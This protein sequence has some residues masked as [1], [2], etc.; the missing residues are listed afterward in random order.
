MWR[1]INLDIPLR[2]HEW[3]SFPTNLANPK[4]GDILQV[5]FFATLP[6]LLVEGTVKKSLFKRWNELLNHPS[7]RIRI[8]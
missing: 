8:F 2:L 4:D 6:T 7:F 5:I 3:I 1:K